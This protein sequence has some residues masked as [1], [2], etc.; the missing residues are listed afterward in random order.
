MQVHAFLEVYQNRSSRLQIEKDIG[1]VELS[2]YA[3]CKALLI[4]S[5]IVVTTHL[6]QP[7]PVFHSPVRSLEK[8]GKIVSLQRRPDGLENLRMALEPYAC[9]ITNFGG[10]RVRPERLVASSYL[11]AKRLE[12]IL[13]PVEV[14]TIDC[15]PDIDSELASFP[16]EGGPCD[17]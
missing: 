4:E 16:C 6:P 3:L 10:P 15:R 17:E 5:R 8:V 9:R 1:I 13:R 12:I 7:H 2:V 11:C 14:S